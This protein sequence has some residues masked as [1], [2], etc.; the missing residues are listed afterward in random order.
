[1]AYPGGFN[2]VSGGKRIV[3]SAVSSTATFVAGNPV[4]LHPCR[5]LLEMRDSKETAIVGI[6]MADAANSIG[7]N[8][9]GLC[10]VLVPMPDTVFITNI[11]TNV[12]SSLLSQGQTG[13]IVKSGNYFRP[14]FDSCVT[15]YVVIVPRGNG[16]T[17]DSADSTVMVSFLQDRL[18]HINSNASFVIF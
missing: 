15:P 12:A 7:G 2:Y 1:M 17:C 14:A 9:T 4:T 6:A 18:A 10:P 3:Y 8:L 11:A 16:T 5:A 13:E